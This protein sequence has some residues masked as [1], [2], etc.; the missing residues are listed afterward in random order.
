MARNRPSLAGAL[1]LFRAAGPVDAHVVSLFANRH[2]QPNRLADVDAVVVN[3]VLEAE[4][5]VREFSHSRAGSALRII[6]E[7]AHIEADSFGTVVVQQILKL[8]FGKMAG[9]KLRTHIA[10]HLN[11]YAHVRFDHRPQR[12]VALAGLE[13]FERRDPQAF[14]IDFGRV[15]RVGSGDTP[16]DVGVVADGRA[17]RDAFTVSEHGFKQK[18]VR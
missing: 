1:D 7:F 2:V 9:R 4:L 17:K 14:L 6:N 18:D 5:A 3:P 15:R 10:E 13:Q 16:A 11:R 12:V 8:A